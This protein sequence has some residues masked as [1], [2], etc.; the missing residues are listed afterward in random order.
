[1]RKPALRNTLKKLRVLPLDGANHHNAMMAQQEML[2]YLALI[3]GQ[4]PVYLL[5]RG[6]DD[7][8]WVAGAVAIAIEAGLQ[9]IEG[10]PW[11]AQGLDKTMPAWFREHLDKQNP[12]APV[13][14]I[15]RTK[16]AAEAVQTS[17]DRS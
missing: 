11:D 14:Y 7:P 2:D 4:K 3:N 13:F 8:R 12:T 6:F 1:M 5:G 9:V 10:P 16:A 17:I 15:C